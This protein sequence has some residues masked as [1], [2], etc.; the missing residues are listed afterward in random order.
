MNLHRNARLIPRDHAVARTGVDITAQSVNA[1][2]SI[3]DWRGVAAV[4]AYAPLLLWGPLLGRLTF[5]YW[6]RVRNSNDRPC[7]SRF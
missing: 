1:P 4:C 2:L 7:I 5:T 3:G 6:R